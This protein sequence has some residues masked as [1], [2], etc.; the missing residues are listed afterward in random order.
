MALIYAYKSTSW[1]SFSSPYISFVWTLKVLEF[2]FDKWARTL[3]IRQNLIACVLY[4][5]EVTAAE[6]QDS[7][8][9]VCD[10]FAF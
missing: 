8:A 7:Q 1:V 6:T 4:C 5:R 3:Y 9:S 2:N 10:F